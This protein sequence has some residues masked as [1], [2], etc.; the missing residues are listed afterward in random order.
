M[1]NR[2]IL[3]LAPAIM[4]IA[5]SCGHNGKSESMDMDE[6]IVFDVDENRNIS[7]MVDTIT[8]IPFEDSHLHVMPEVTKMN[9][10][11]DYVVIGSKSLSKLAVYTKEG[12]F[13]YE[14]DKRGHG[15]GEYLEIANFTNTDSVIYIIDNFQHSIHK[16][17]LDNGTYLGSDRITF[18]AWDME[19]FDDDTFL[20]TMIRNNR[21]AKF[22]IEHDIETGVW[23]TNG[24]WEVTKSYIHMSGDYCEMYG[25]QRFFTKNDDTIIFHTLKDSGYYRFM[26]SQSPVFV[27][28]V[29]AN[30]L[31]SDFEG[32]VEDAAERGYGYVAETPFEINGNM[33]AMVASNG[34]EDLYVYN[35]SQK[36]FLRNSAENAHNGMI[37]VLGTLGLSPIG[38]LADYEMYQYLISNGFAR[39]DS[40]TENLLRK[41]GA[42]A[43]VYTM[44]GSVE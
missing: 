38:Y 4:F 42:A 33:I 37:A 3:A 2:F 29:F 41:G 28:V 18:M 21:D 44:K 30:P 36:K 19:A 23:E 14:I 20:F 26:K 7:S 15:N 16:Y 12:K 13:K 6:S 1:K 27:P 31:P 24:R 9:I 35:A 11:K 10:S 43:V 32:S 17:L 22:D 25:K 34:V 39:A 5:V 40:V 8:Y